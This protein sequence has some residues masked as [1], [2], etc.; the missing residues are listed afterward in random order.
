MASGVKTLVNN[1][2][3]MILVTLL[4]RAGDNPETPPCAV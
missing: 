4:A 1:C 2:D 3:Q